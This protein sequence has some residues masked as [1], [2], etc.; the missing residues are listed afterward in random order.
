MTKILKTIFIFIVIVIFPFQDSFSQK[1]ISH[2]KKDKVALQKGTRTKKYN[3]EYKNVSYENFKTYFYTDFE[4]G[5][6]PPSGYSVQNPDGD[7]TWD[8]SSEASG[9]GSG[10]YSAFINLFDYSSI[11]EIDSLISPDIVELYGGDTVKFDVAY[12][13]YGNS[14]DS[15]FVCLSIDGGFSYEK[16]YAKG[17]STLSTTV[18]DDYFIPNALEWRRES[19]VLPSIVN[20]NSVKIAFVVYNDYGNNL[21]IDNIKIGRLPKTD[22][23]VASVVPFPEPF[24]VNTP[25]AIKSNLEW[26]GLQSATNPTS[27]QATYKIGSEPTSPDDGVT[28]TFN[29]FWLNNKSSIT[30][31]QT[32]TPTL[33]ND[34]KVYVRTFYILDSIA[35][36]NSS[37]ANINV[38]KVVSQFPYLEEFEQGSNG[39]VSGSFSPTNSW[40]IGNPNKEQITSSHSGNNCFVTSLDSTYTDFENSYLLSP[41]FNFSNVFDTPILSFYHNYQIEGGYDGG[42]IEYTLDGNEFYPLGI[43]SDTS[44][45]YWFNYSDSVAYIGVGCWG[46]SSLDYD[47]NL[48]GWVQSAIRLYGFEGFNYIRF[49]FRIGSDES[50]TEEGWAIDDIKISFASQISGL[51]FEDMNMNG[52][53]DVGEIPISEMKIYREGPK[54]DE[55]YVYEIDSILTDVNGNYVFSNL[56]PGSVSLYQEFS[57]NWI[58]AFPQDNES[59]YFQYN[60]GDTVQSKNFGNA[61]GGSISGFKWNDV[62]LNGI[63]DSSESKLSNWKF[64]IKLGNQIDSVVNNSDGSFTFSRL[65]PGV[66]TISEINKRGWTQ[67][68]PANNLPY[69]VNLNYAQNVIDKNF[70]NAILG[71]ISGRVFEDMNQNG[72]IDIGELGIGNIAI[73]LNGPIVSDTIFSSEEGEYY[74]RDL[75]EGSYTVLI[76]PSEN[77]QTTFPTNGIYE[78]EISGGSIITEV[79]FGIFKFGHVAGKIFEDKNA[80]GVFDNGENIFSNTKVIKT[81][82]DILDSTFTDINGNYKFG[83]LNYGNHTFK[84]E[85]SEEWNYSV[86][87]NGMYVLSIVS[88]T[89]KD[90]SNFGMY[91]FGKIMGTIFNDENNNGV[92]DIGE[93]GLSEW[94][95]KLSGKKIDSTLTSQDGT[96]SFENLVPGNYVI[97]QVKQNTW[98]QTYPPQNGFYSFALSSNEIVENKNFGN[99]RRTAI[100]GTVFNDK[101][102]NGIKNQGDIGISNWTIKLVKDG[103][104]LTVISDSLGRFRFE[105]LENGNYTL[106]QQIQID[107]VPI[108]PLAPN[109]YNISLEFGNVDT[110]YLFG[111]FKYGK[112]FG[113]NFNDGNGNGIRDAGESGIPNWKIY[114][115]GV[116][117]D[118]TLTDANGNYAFNSLLF[119]DYVVKEEHPTNW[120]QTFPPAPGTHNISINS[121]KILEKN[122]GNKSIVSVNEENSIPKNFVLYQNT[123]NPFN[124]S[125]SIFF[126]LPNGAFVSLKI[127]NML[128]QEVANVFEKEFPSGKHSVEFIATNISSGIYFYK[129]NAI[130]INGKIFSSMK[131]MIL[132]K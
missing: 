66:Y 60:G 12:A 2:I 64:K 61:K 42:V 126:D 74:F 71:E 31:S 24:I 7:I 114:I 109:E 122:F 17:G 63:Y 77:Y 73:L 118:S 48:D 90:S 5:V 80:N 19:I 6:F 131:K 46:Y 95:V 20:E 82:N 99:Y 55:F 25:I 94:K 38:T 57:Q 68:Y 43:Y 14:N 54:I 53:Q 96:Y 83:S 106:S 130:D 35:D 124:P 81:Y 44:G 40:T 117:S 10:A 110:N 15:L 132:N 85:F 67:I 128:G 88:G 69:M 115:N 72:V 120:I 86:P 11:E 84:T 13:L 123:P 76:L 37:F 65:L 113:I 45:R 75:T 59:H 50:G 129:L 56:L 16:I 112:V 1:K 62:N 101:N 100:G 121:G 23:K 108:V 58:Q 92:F 127:Y 47:D 89:K 26:W 98:I 21:Y 30:F 116:F 91:K 3:G 39:W 9:F 36:N 41:V 105:N 119:G 125:T 18:S 8:L 49:R 27:I 79:D 51:V 4:N 104:T 29:V 102:A 78:I 32:F 34:Y 22:V 28:Q 107:W 93:V 33:A 103:D 97:K 111:N 52:T 87:A 70:G